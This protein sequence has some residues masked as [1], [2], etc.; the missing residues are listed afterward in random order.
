MIMNRN[1]LLVFFDQAESSLVGRLVSLETEPFKLTPVVEPE[2]CPEK[3]DRVVG[4]VSARMVSSLLREIPRKQMRYLSKTLP[5]LVEDDLIAPIDKMHIVSQVVTDNKVR[6]FAIDHDLMQSCISWAGDR[7]LILDELYVDADLMTLD[8][9]TLQDRVIHCDSGYLFKGAEGLI[10]S[11]D[12]VDQLAGI[13]NCYLGAGPES[14]EPIE[15]Y[16]QFFS[17]LIVDEVPSSLPPVNLLQRGYVPKTA[18]AERSALVRRVILSASV[19]LMVQIFYW[20][21][22]GA[23]YNVEAQQLQEKATLTYRQHFPSEK[24]IIDIRSQ[25]EGH[26]AQAGKPQ[27]TTS[28]LTVLEMVG[29]A[30]QE[31]SVEGEVLVRSIQYKNQAGDVVVE[32]TAPSVAIIEQVRAALIDGSDLDVQTE[33]INQN[34]D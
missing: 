5:F 14:L 8:L 20:V 34:R 12:S 30:I 31:H 15:N 17:K 9:N 33:Q 11:F 2:Q 29:D 25:A 32:V 13:E 16:Q 26:L 1:L 24:T 28:F 10:A 18:L 19:L 21:L 7:N 22:V 6:I 23:D 3:I 4:I 27:G